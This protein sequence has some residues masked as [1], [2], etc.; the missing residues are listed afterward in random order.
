[1]SRRA[2]RFRQAVQRGLG[3]SLDRGVTLAWR[4]ERWLMRATGRTHRGV[5]ALV[6]T[7]AGEL[8]LL[9]L[10]YLSGWHLPGGGRRRGEPAKAAVLR[11]LREELGACTH[12]PAVHLATI[13]EL[14]RGVRCEIDLFRVGDCVLAGRPRLNAEV[15]TVPAWPLDGLPDRAAVAR[16]RLALLDV[17]APG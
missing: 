17:P 10:R 2:V 7:P 16:A 3:H 14:S 4:A 13:H 11:E 6:F 12:G 9:E 1:M 8:V 5:Q 15:R